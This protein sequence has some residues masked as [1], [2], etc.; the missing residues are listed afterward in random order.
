MRYRVDYY[1]IFDGWIGGISDKPSEFD[2]PGQ[3]IALRDRKNAELD[4]ANKL[5]GEHYGVI[6]LEKD[7]EVDC[8]TR[9]DGWPQP[10]GGKAVADGFNTWVWD[11][12]TEK[13]EFCI[14]VVGRWT[15]EESFLRVRKVFKGL[16][17]NITG[18]I[19][20]KRSA[21]PDEMKGTIVELPE[22]KD[23]L[24]FEFLA[25]RKLW[26]LIGRVAEYDAEMILH[27][28][29]MGQRKGQDSN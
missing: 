27:E 11:V 1:D 17:I 12:M 9:K 28:K 26:E 14:T 20:R 25:G 7:R 2:D 6:D 16:G 4:E 29:Q 8:P 15:K 13:G 23:R 19:A 5:A 24:G 10:A 18:M 3:A 22:P 21:G